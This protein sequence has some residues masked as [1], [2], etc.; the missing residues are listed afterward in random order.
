ML[1][2]IAFAIGTTYL[3]KNGKAKYSWITLVPMVF[4]AITTLTAAVINITDNYLPSRNY[5]LAVISGILLIMVLAVLAESLKAWYSILKEN[6]PIDA[7]ML[8]Q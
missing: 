2:V 6:K 4:V 5:T 3:M 8:T 7:N 1:A